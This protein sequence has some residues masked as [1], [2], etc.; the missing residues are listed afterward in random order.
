MSTYG[1]FLI[2]HDRLDYTEFGSGDSWV[3]LIHGLLMPRKMH[4]PLATA[5]AEK[6]LHVI[7]IDL[8]GHGTSDR[9]ADQF[10]YS[11]TA[12]AEQ[13]I[14]L[15]DHLGA[16]QAV[17]GGTS[18]GANVSLEA[19]AIA[20]EPIRG[21]IVE[22]PVLDNALDVGLVAF[23]P[24]MLAARH[25]PFTIKAPALLSRLVPRRN[26]PFWAG[27]LLDTVNQQP[28]P[29]G[30]L[31]HGVVFGRIA[32]PS[33]L[34][35]KIQSPMLVVGHPSDP[36]HPATDATMLATEVPNSRFVRAGSIL[37][38]R[39]HPDRLNEEAAGF[40]LDCWKRG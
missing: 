23:G 5:L 21:L 24:L 4:E 6:G 14:L 30:D 1:S 17:V 28:G 31:L 2:G 22:M 37:E 26:V 33:R 12:F 15:L 19:A 10:L 32:P 29:M 40:A 38:W 35:R 13:V 3:V 18:L 16:D 20:P 7:T 27:I 34:R 36:I 8:L 39:F 11:M 25:L 9:P